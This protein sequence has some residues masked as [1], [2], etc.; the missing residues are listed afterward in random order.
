MIRKLCAYSE[1]LVHELW[2]I[3]YSTFLDKE[4]IL[5]HKWC[6]YFLAA[7]L[8]SN[9]SL[10]SYID[11][12]ADVCCSNLDDPLSGQV[13][14]SNTTVGST[15]NYTCNQGYTISNGNS[16]RTCEAN[17]QWSGSPPSCECE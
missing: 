7:E 11:F 4:A 3:V 6:Q 10:L 17:G 5:I 13:E 12:S 2:N 14:L 9:T 8:T 16:T 15:A 1:T